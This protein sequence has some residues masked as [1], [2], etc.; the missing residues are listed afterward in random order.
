[1]IEVNTIPKAGLNVSKVRISINSAAEF[2]MQ[3]SIVGWGKYKDGE[4]KEDGLN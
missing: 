4:G 3:F 1:M 2:S